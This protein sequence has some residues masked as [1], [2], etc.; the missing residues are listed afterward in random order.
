MINEIC[1]LLETNGM[2]MLVGDDGGLGLIQAL[3]FT[4]GESGTTASVIQENIIGSITTF[5]SDSPYV[6]KFKNNSNKLIDI[7]N[8]SS[9]SLHEFSNL[10]IAALV[11]QRQIKLYSVSDG[12]LCCYIY[13]PK[14]PG[15]SLRI[16]KMADGDFRALN[17]IHMTSTAQLI[18]RKQSGNFLKDKPNNSV[19]NFVRM[20][21]K[22]VNN[23]FKNKRQ[24]G[25]D[26]GK[27]PPNDYRKSLALQET[28]PEFPPNFDHEKSL[29]NSQTSI[30]G[31]FDSLLED[32][33]VDA[34]IDA[35]L[36]MRKT[37][38]PTKIKVRR[39][40]SGNYF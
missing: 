21:D 17:L 32:S 3:A 16:F 9:S 39:H 6:A 15:K 26:F 20:H 18:Q 7:L 27:S 25:R 34:E 31:D 33:V 10:K 38:T 13:G 22:E 40:L 36:A 14:T 30:D 4:L 12:S 28:A 24:E 29:I 37:H 11:L 2:R 5:L 35:L 8:D 23:V 1:K 19:M